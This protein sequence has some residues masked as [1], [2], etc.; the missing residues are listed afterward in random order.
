MKVTVELISPLS[1]K[2][3]PRLSAVTN[4]QATQGQRMYFLV[5]DLEATCDEINGRKIKMTAT[6]IIKFPA[7]LVNTTDSTII[8]TFHQYIKPTICPTLSEFCTKLTGITQ[9]IVD[10]SPELH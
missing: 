1:E 6:E 7:V 5:M 8:S 4:Q 3:N 2:G 10:S 9:D